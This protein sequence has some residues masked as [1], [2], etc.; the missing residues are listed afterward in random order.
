MES[1]S[2]NLPRRG[3]NK[4]SVALVSGERNNDVLPLDVARLGSKNTN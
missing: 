4:D 1:T 2:N 3:V